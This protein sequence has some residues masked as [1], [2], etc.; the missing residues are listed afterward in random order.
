MERG[1]L[2][3]AANAE[4][5][6]LHGPK[7]PRLAPSCPARNS[8][9]RNPA[10]EADRASCHA[11]GRPMCERP[12]NT[13]RPPIASTRPTRSHVYGQRTRGPYSI[14]APRRRRTTHRMRPPNSSV[15]TVEGSTTSCGGRSGTEDRRR[16]LPRRLD[17]VTGR[18]PAC[19]T[20]RPE[21]APLGRAPRRAPVMG[22]PLGGVLDAIRR[23]ATRFTGL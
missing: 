12:N 23:S 15:P 18:R 11:R 21:V 7:L 1:V 17:P 2:D 19:W 16:Y 6:T 20:T 13:L 22:P 5:R 9:T 3:A 14:G 4:R 10:V 8:T